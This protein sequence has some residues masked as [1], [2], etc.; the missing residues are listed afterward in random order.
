MGA[1][2]IL[3]FLPCEEVPGVYEMFER[4]AVEDHRE[5]RRCRPSE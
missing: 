2:L 3:S 4:W 5:E 1:D